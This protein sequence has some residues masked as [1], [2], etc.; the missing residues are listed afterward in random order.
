[1]IHRKHKHPNSVAPCRNY[2]NGDCTFTQESCFWSHENKDHASQSI[3]CYVCDQTFTNKVQ[4]MN[5]R[6]ISHP[7]CIEPCIKYMKGE[8][9][10]QSKFCWFKHTD[11]P[12]KILEEEN[13]IK[14][15]ISVFQ[16]AT[17]IPKPPL[18]SQENK[19]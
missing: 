8:C 18:K 3:T 10:F 1:M 11:T 12:S 17:K 2:K 6:K 5:H 4:V 16:E 13:D 19:A 9:P 7:S 14:D 15:N